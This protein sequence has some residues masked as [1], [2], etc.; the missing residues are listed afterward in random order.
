MDLGLSVFKFAKDFIPKLWGVLVDIR[1]KRNRELNA[2][3]DVFGDPFLL[4]KY[5][6]EPDCQ[7]VNPVDYAE[8]EAIV[9]EPM[10]RRMESF[11]SGD[12]NRVNRQ[13]FILSDA[14]MGKTSALM[15]LKL[16][17]LTAFWPQGRSCELIKLGVDALESISKIQNKRKTILLL[18]ALDEDPLAWSRVSVRLQELLQATKAFFRVVI[19]C[20]TQFFDGNI[21]PFN[22]RG[23][24]EVS[25]FVC[26][27]IFAS[28]FSDHQVEQYIRKRYGEKVND[29][30]WM[31]RA[32]G[33]VKKMGFLRM[34]PMLL[35]HM[36][37][38]LASAEQS[39]NEYS[40]YRALVSSWLLREQSKSEVADPDYANKLKKACVYAAYQMN[41]SGR[42]YFTVNET[43]IL[44]QIVGKL[45][46]LR[47]FDIG[48]RSLLNKDSNGNFRFSHYS[49]SEY[50]VLEHCL[51]LGVDEKIPADLHRSAFMNQLGVAWF[52]QASKHERI[53][54][55][56]RLID[57]Q[58]VDFNKSSLDGVDFLKHNFDGC[59]FCEASLVNVSFGGSSLQSVDFRIAVFQGVD[60]S[61]SNLLQSNFTGATFVGCNFSHVYACEA[62]FEGVKMIDC[63]FTDANLFRS[64]FNGSRLK[65]LNFSGANLK[66]MSTQGVVFDGSEGWTN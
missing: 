22:R 18:D 33:I 16:A 39:W 25:G 19:T 1:S 41:K 17:H 32:K 64:K 57:F 52:H 55:N 11:F 20:R 45:D 26:P 14:G 27:V 24:I 15:M 61:N 13:L 21:D 63:D 58:G 48:G 46:G 38:L 66:E 44:S 51:N 65:R 29:E 59:S 9:R 2:I 37:D 53:Q 47:S 7:Q 10:F 6:I 62:A 56:I 60:F 42:A 50:L 8:D 36:D 34:R 40:I 54:R 23:M 30:K 28:L 3:A 35:A 12:E 43:K 31:C 4:A 5:Y 49:I